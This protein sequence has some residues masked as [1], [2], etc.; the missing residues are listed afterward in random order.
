M[1]EKTM[2]ECSVCGH[3]L[4]CVAGMCV[5]CR[6]DLVRCKECGDLFK[7]EDIVDGICAY[8]ENAQEEE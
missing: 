5:D 2:E 3:V 4:P 6:N 7:R 1:I 8:C